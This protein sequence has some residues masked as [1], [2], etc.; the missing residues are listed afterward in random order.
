M[1]GMWCGKR[2]DLR[3]KSA[4]ALMGNRDHSFFFLLEMVDFATVLLSSLGGRW[5]SA[6]ALIYLLPP[7]HSQVKRAGGQTR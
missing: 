3:L 4:L 1:I 2:S 6:D 7:V 5:A